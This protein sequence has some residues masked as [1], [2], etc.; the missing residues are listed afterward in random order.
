MGGAGRGKATSILDVDF[1]PLLDDM[2]R[3][4]VTIGR[5][6]MRLPIRSPIR[7]MLKTLTDQTRE[8]AALATGDRDYFSGKPH[9]GTT[10]SLRP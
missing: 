3:L 4:N 10:S 6:N 8:V 1:G 9:T 7:A 2:G 5:I